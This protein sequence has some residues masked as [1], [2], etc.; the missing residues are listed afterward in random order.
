MKSFAVLFLFLI[1]I[2]NMSAQESKSV[3]D[4]TMDNITG[5]PVDLSSYEGKVLLIV[6][7][8]SK[9]GLTPQYEDL[10]KLFQK[11]KDQDFMILGFPANNFMGQEPG[12]DEEIATFCQKNYGVSFDMFS[13]ISV[14]GKDIHPLYEFLTSDEAGEK[15][16]WNFQK[17]LIDKNG[18]LVKTFSP[19]T[20]PFDDELVAALEAELKK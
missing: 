15:V 12:T 13:K 8:A 20:L 11:Y 1:S 16:A 4:F 18:N 19:R 10:E 2:F 7:V 9:C 5:E 3:H 14:K 6:N 17:F